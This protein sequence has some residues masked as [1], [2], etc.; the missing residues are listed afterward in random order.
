[1]EKSQFFNGK[2]HY[3]YGHFSIAFCMFTR[4]YESWIN[5]NQA[6]GEGKPI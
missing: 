4:G 2:T 6:N 1:M 3:F 5:I